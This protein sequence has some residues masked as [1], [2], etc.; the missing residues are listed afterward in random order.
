MSMFTGRRGTLLTRL[1]VAG[2]L[3]SV[4]G[5]QAASA[6]ASGQA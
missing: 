4:V 2:F 1:A 6:M 3:F 5:A